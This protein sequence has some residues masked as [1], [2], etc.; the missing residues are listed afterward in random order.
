VVP[1]LRIGLF[2]FLSMTQRVDVKRDVFDEMTEMRVLDEGEE[3]A[4]GV[5]D[6]G[7]PAT[8]V[9]VAVEGE[10]EGMVE[11][12]SGNAE[13]GVGDEATGGKVEV[14]L[15]EGGDHVDNFGR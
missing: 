5:G 2:S 14:V 13:E 9:V 11:T 12:R 8:A 1:K 3:G 7:E 4:V 6:A 15:D 10:V